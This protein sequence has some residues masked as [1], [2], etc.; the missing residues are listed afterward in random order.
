MRVFELIMLLPGRLTGL[1]S[2]G[3]MLCTF[4]LIVHH[5]AY[6]QTISLVSRADVTTLSGLLRY[7][8]QT[9]SSENA[10][11]EIA[12]YSSQK[13]RIFYT[14]SSPVLLQVGN[15]SYD[16]REQ[17]ANTDAVYH[18]NDTLPEGV[19]NLY[20]TMYAY[21]SY[22]VI[23]TYTDI[24]RVAPVREQG[25]AGATF[26]SPSLY[27]EGNY[28]QFT[29]YYPEYQNNYIRKGGS[30]GLNLFGLPF[31]LSA[32]G[33]YQFDTKQYLLDNFSLNFN[34]NEYINGLKRKASAY[35]EEKSFPGLKAIYDSVNQL[36]IDEALSDY[37]LKSVISQYTG[38]EKVKKTYVNTGLLADFDRFEEM[39]SRVTSLASLGEEEI[40]AYVKDM[41]GDTSLR[42]METM[43]SGRKQNPGAV[44]DGMDTLSSAV[45]AKYVDKKVLEKLNEGERQRLMRELLEICKNQDYLALLDKYGTTGKAREFFTRKS[46]YAYVADQLNQL[47]GKHPFLKGKKY[48]DYKEIYEKKDLKKIVDG[49]QD[50]TAL[51]SFLPK[52]D[53][54]LRLSYLKKLRIGFFQPPG[55]ENVPAFSVPLFG[56]SVVYNKSPLIITSFLGT[57]KILAPNRNTYFRD[58][59]QKHAATEGS[60]G[61]GYGDIASKAIMVRYT[62]M[63][64]RDTVS[65][66]MEYFNSAGFRVLLGNRKRSVNSS[67]EADYHFSS[68]GHPF[69]SNT[70]LMLSN[71]YSA[72]RKL[73]FTQAVQYKGDHFYNS[74]NTVF[75]PYRLLRVIHGVSGAVGKV[76]PNFMLQHVYENYA[77]EQQVYTSNFYSVSASLKTSKTGLL[78][79]SGSL[80]NARTSGR[81]ENMDRN[82]NYTASAAYS[83]HFSFKKLQY[84]LQ[85]RSSV[86][87]SRLYDYTSYYAEPIN[88]FSSQ[89]KEFINYN[90]SWLSAFLLKNISMNYEMFLSHGDVVNDDAYI[91]IGNSL[92]I[93]FKKKAHAY[94]LSASVGYT[95]KTEPFYGVMANASFR[96]TDYLKLTTTLEYKKQRIF[97]PDMRYEH[98]WLGNI[99]MNIII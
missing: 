77:G 22:Q 96:I 35:L 86:Q 23:S 81:Q 95:L 93:S 98:G 43:L 64:R 50:V 82:I 87:R 69:L 44:T 88:V 19:Y 47:A 78:V 26:S 13:G 59:I 11:I 80:G 9:L 41:A 58:I 66:H 8:I 74:T 36:N 57:T 16:L 72:G 14:R 63:F 30:V 76:I 39:K 1:K 24:I 4:C 29:R 99:L 53:G 52:P 27:I 28:D 17:P 5:A 67:I 34:Y 46:Q 55:R 65:E 2:G 75:N 40:L 15:L 20:V 49:Y 56:Y 18:Y 73:E 45:L 54:K 31:D 84:T 21:P 12:V 91:D 90:I 51:S 61:I 25:R 62:T 94:N 33:M 37:E 38:L 6:S 70:T 97:W 83:D 71:H 32:G 85:L 92:L 7:N 60:V 68:G 3:I 48:K 79:G 42:K 10:L 89:Y